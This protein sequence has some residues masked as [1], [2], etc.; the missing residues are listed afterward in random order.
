MAEKLRDGDSAGISYSSNFKAGVI[1]FVLKTST[2]SNGDKVRFLI[3]GVPQTL[4]PNSSKPFELS[5][6]VNWKSYSFPLTAGNHTIQWIYKKDDSFKVGQDKVWLDNVTLPETTQEIVIKDPA[7]NSITSGAFTAQLP[8]AND[9]GSSAAQTFKIMNTGNADLFGLQVS[10]EGANSGDFTITPPKEA[11]LP[12]SSTNFG[13]SFT[14][15]GAGLRTATV[16]VRS[17]DVD[18]SNFLIQVEGNALPYPRIGLSQATKQLVDNDKNRLN[19][20]KTQVRNGG[21]SKSFTI[22]NNGSAPLTDLAISKSGK[23]R[24]VYELGSLSATSLAPG[25]S[26]II[27]VSFKPK[28]I[29]GNQ[30]ASISISSNDGQTGRFDVK[31]NGEGI[32]KKK[33]KSKEALVLK[34]SLASSSSLEAAFGSFDN[35]SATDYSTAVD[36][37]DGQKYLSL[38][39]AKSAENAGSVIEVSSDLIDWY[40]GDQ[41]T[42]TILDNA[43]TLKVRDNTPVTPE[44]KRYIR[45]K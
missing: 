18:E 34:S 24:R 36:V 8:E 2:E 44:A 23:F 20:G 10:V 6:E 31:L 27:T 45:L 7:D 33:K 13:V 43:T 3:D 29:R 15:K 21:K 40:S 26:T 12:G 37:V 25:E 9:G 22:T 41:Y 32:A 38:T 4:S 5:G 19:Y 35:F 39:V 30:K 28:K 11:V 16:R 14:P 17:N 1:G 42:T